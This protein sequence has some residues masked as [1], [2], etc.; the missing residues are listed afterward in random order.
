MDKVLLT[1]NR[2]LNTPHTTQRPERPRPATPRLLTL[3]A[4]RLHINLHLVIHTRQRGCRV[5]LSQALI[6]LAIIDVPELV[7]AV[8]RMRVEP[9]HASQLAQPPFKI[10]VR[11]DKRIRVRRTKSPNTDVQHLLRRAAVRLDIAAVRVERRR[12]ALLERT[13]P[14]R[15]DIELLVRV[16]DERLRSGIRQR[17]ILDDVA[18]RLAARMQR[19]VQHARVQEVVQPPPRVPVEREAEV[20]ERRAADP[21]P[22]AVVAEQVLR[23][24]DVVGD[25]GGAG[26][27][28]VLHVQ[29]EPGVPGMAEGLG[30][31]E[32]TGQLIG[33]LAGDDDAVVGRE[34]HA[35]DVVVVGV[36]GVRLHGLDGL[37][38]RLVRV[39]CGLDEL[40]G[41]D[42]LQLDE[43]GHAQ[44]ADSA[45]G[46]AKQIRVLGLGRLEYAAVR[47]DHL[48]RVDRAVEEPV[49]ERAAF[50]R[51]AG[52]A[53]PG[54]DAGELHHDGGHEAVLQR[55][56]DQPVH[57][58]VGLD[59]RRA[60]LRVHR[61]HIAQVADV[62]LA[63]APDG[64]RAVR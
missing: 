20:I 4:V 49:L 25:R 6:P 48:D 31:R 50:A 17:Q 52:E 56:L 38:H 5:L 7:L 34:Q 42:Q 53:A 15:P 60:R 23:Q 1:L 62:D 27:R 55:R 30:L 44:T 2:L 47:H 63:V 9:L 10:P 37:A 12:R 33:H 36:A 29:V 35:V 57:G 8:V 58:H 19:F 41:L 28:L 32:G 3:F 51:C 22:A 61:Q 43:S 45:S 18:A 40:L 16:F 14:Q 11:S 24:R 26:T 39:V 46:A 59:Q 13:Q 21:E 54:R 64:A